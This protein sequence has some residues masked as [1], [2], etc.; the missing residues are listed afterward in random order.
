MRML[1]KARTVMRLDVLIAAADE[2]FRRLL[3]R[4]IG[5]AVTVVGEAQDAGIAARLVREEKPSV[6]LLDM[7]LPGVVVETPRQMRGDNPSLKVIL[8]TGHDEEAYLGG[9]GRSGA[10]AFLPKRR[11]KTDVLPLLQEVTGLALRGRSDGGG[12]R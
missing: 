2:E 5:G 7:D 10:D 3:R 9:T 8:M 1:W 11:V 6:V 4:L 12:A